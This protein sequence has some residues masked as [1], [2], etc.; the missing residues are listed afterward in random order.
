MTGRSSDNLFPF[1][2]PHL[3]DRCAPV[4]RTAAFSAN[5]P[6]RLQLLRDQSIHEAMAKQQNGA[7]ICDQLKSLSRCISSCFSF[8][9]RLD[10]SR[11][12]A[13][14]CNPEKKCPCKWGKARSSPS[15]VRQLR[16]A[17]NLIYKMR[18]KAQCS[19]RRQC[20]R[21]I[22]RNDHF[23]CGGQAYAGHRDGM[24]YDFG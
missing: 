12:T 19:N 15:S 9:G 8:S 3:I 10:S 16:L 18:S 7:F 6:R 21:C 4:P 11:K 1:P 23:C 13:Q 14:P 24:F 5:P 17:K 2:Q 22:A 20:S